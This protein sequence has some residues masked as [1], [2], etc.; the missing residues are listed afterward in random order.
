MDEAID[1]T[2]IHTAESSD[3]TSADETEFWSSSEDE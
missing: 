3:Y 1:S 2:I